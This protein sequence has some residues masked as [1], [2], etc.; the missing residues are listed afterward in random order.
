MR[1]RHGLSLP[2]V[3]KPD[4]GERGQGV[5]VARCRRDVEAHLAQLDS[6]IVIQEYVPGVEFGVF[7]VRRPSEPRGAVVSITEKRLPVV[8]ADGERT[9]EALILDDPRAVCMIVGLRDG[10]RL[11]ALAAAPDE[12]ASFEFIVER[13][14]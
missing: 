10:D 8:I 7:Y 9:V 12:D 4:Q 6:D 5:V 11:S 2:I 13:P 14:R 3:L 1:R